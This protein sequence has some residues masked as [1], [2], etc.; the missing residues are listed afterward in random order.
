MRQLLLG[1]DQMA[2]TLELD[3]DQP[4]F[5]RKVTGREPLDAAETAQVERLGIRWLTAG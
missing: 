1:P 4:K 2:A 3:W 5:L